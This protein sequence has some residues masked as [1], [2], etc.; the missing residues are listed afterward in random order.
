MAKKA[1]AILVALLIFKNIGAIDSDT[2]K[3]AAIQ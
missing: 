2:Q 3:V 1:S